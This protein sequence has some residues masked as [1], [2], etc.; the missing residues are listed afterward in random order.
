[1]RDSRVVCGRESSAMF[2][3]AR[4]PQRIFSEDATSPQGPRQHASVVTRSRACE[5]CCASLCATRNEV[6]TEVLLAG[7]CDGR[8]LIATRWGALLGSGL[9]VGGRREMI[10]F[11]E[12]S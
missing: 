2:F 4:P 9:R 6:T 7:N 1:M 8:F 3:G 12:T 5:R 11:V 10:D